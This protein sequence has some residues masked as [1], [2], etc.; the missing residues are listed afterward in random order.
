[1]VQDWITFELAVRIRNSK[2]DSDISVTAKK[3]LFKIR[4]LLFAI[5][6][7]AFAAFSIGTIISAK[8]SEVGGYAFGYNECKV[9]NIMGIF[10]LAQIFVMTSLVI[11]LF[12]EALRA[13]NRELRQ[14]G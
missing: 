11:W 9:I 4:R 7:L 10:F 8:N 14:C 1:M 12:V 3:N 5:I 13:V 6:S 2:G